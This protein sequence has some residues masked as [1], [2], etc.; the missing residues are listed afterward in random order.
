MDRGIMAW[1]GSI[2]IWPANRIPGDVYTDDLG[3][4]IDFRRI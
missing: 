3:R 2:E 1:F 4:V